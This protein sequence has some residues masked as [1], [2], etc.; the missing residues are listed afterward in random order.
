MS[1][2]SRFPKSRQFPFTETARIKSTLKGSFSNLTR[3]FEPQSTKLNSVIFEINN[4]AVAFFGNCNA[5]NALDVSVELNAHLNK[6][7]QSYPSK[8]LVFLSRLPFLVSAEQ[9]FSHLFGQKNLESFVPKVLGLQACN[10]S[11]KRNNI[12]LIDG[13][14]V[15][16]HRFVLAAHRV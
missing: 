3:Y 13:V 16:Y 2:N 8:R 9:R 5:Y 7:V 1:V 4:V 14:L 10:V 12:R 11:R 6:H 15:V